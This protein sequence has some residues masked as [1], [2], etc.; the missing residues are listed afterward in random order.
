MRQ[1]TERQAKHILLALYRQ[2]RDDFAEARANFGDVNN[3]QH[4]RVPTD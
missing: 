4:T 2:A 1:F 3:T